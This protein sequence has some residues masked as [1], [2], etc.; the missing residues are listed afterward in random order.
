MREL[1]ATEDAADS[2][3]TGE[4]ST[5][6][7]DLE[8]LREEGGE[9]LLVPMHQLN[10]LTYQCNDLQ[11]HLEGRYHGLVRDGAC[12]AIYDLTSAR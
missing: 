2:R 1:N 12:C 11:Q 5:S 4:Q 8:K 7:Q 6:V 9:Y 3:G 10:R